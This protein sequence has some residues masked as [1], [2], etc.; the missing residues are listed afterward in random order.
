VNKK[1]FSATVNL[2]AAL[3]NISGISAEFDFN[4][5]SLLW[6]NAICINQGDYGEKSSQVQMMGLIFKSAIK[7]LAWLGPEQDNSTE[8]IGHIKQL[9][10]EIKP[11]PDSGVEIL[12]RAFTDS[13]QN[14]GTLDTT[15]LSLALSRQEDL[16]RLFRNRAFWNR[17]WILQELALAKSL[18]YICGRR[19]LT[20]RDLSMT[21]AWLRP[22]NTSKPTTIDWETWFGFKTNAE[23]SFYFPL[24]GIALGSV[25]AGAMNDWNESFSQPY[26]RAWSIFKTSSSLLATDPRDKVYSLLSKVLI[27]IQHSGSSLTNKA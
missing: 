19:S 15:L 4:S 20:L 21:M 25:L 23:A 16:V 3:E 2:V 1:K 9:A 17:A 13:L 6:V 11:S 8:V 18:V 14:L 27:L 24:R 26:V 7:V 12:S 22:L 10:T 5:S